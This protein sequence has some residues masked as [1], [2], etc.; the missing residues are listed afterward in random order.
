M[1]LSPRAGKWPGAAFCVLVLVTLGV[2]VVAG[3][4]RA[5]VT[6]I[7]NE[8][9]FAGAL[10][11]TIHES[12]PGVLANDFAAGPYRARLTQDSPA[13]TSLDLNG[14]GSFTFDPNGQ[15][16]GEFDFA[17]CIQPAGGGGCLT[18]ETT[19][20][21]FSGEPYVLS[22]NYNVFQGTTL[23]LAAPGLL[24]GAGNR[25]SDDYLWVVGP[26]DVG[27]FDSHKSGAI[28][29]TP[30]PDFIG[31][32]AFFYCLTTDENKANGDCESYYGMAGSF[33]VYPATLGQSVTVNQDAS[34]HGQLYP[35]PQGGVSFAGLIT[36]A[37][38][39][40]GVDVNNDGTF[41]Y[42]P[43][44][45]Y[46][47]PDQFQF[48]LTQDDV[49]CMSGS[50]PATV[51][52]TVVPLE[53]PTT[54]T[55]DAPATAPFSQPVDVVATVSPSAATGTVAFAEGG[56]PIAGCGA[57]PV[58]GGQ[59]TCTRGGLAIGP[60]VFTASF[61]GSGLYL[62]SAAAP[63]TT[64]VTR[65][66][67]ALTYTGATTAVTGS[68]FTAAARLTRTAGGSTPLPGQPVQFAIT[69]DSCTGTTNPQGIASCVL[70][71]PAPGSTTVS[72]AFAGDGTDQAA[73]GSATVAVAKIPTTTV[74]VPDA[75]TPIWGTA[76]QLTATVS[77]AAS[78][79]VAFTSGSTTISGCD[80]VAVSGGIAV[81]TT[82]DLP[83]GADV[84]TAS[85]S[86]DATHATSSGQ[87]TVTVGLRPTALTYTGDTSATVGEPATL[88]GTLTDVTSGDPVVGQNLTFTR[89]ALTCSALTGPDGRAACTVT[90]TAVAQSGPVTAD[91][92]GDAHHA[93]AT[94]TGALAVAAAPTTTTV[95][96]PATAVF[97]TPVVLT[98]TVTP[99]DGSGTVVFSVGGTPIAGCAGLPLA[100]VGGS[101]QAE[102][103]T[104]ELAV[105]ADEVTATFSG[106]AD[107]TTSSGTATVTVGP[108]PTAVRYTG[109]T[110]GTVTQTLSVSAVLTNIAGSATPIAGQA[111]TF[112]LAD[113]SCTGTTD[114]DGRAACDLTL[115]DVAQTGALT[116]TYAATT[117]YQAATTAADVTVDPVAT[118]TT[119]A[120][121]ATGT[122][123]VPVTI[124]A[125]IA[126]SAGAGT[127]D[128]GS[129]GAPVAG[130][131]DVPLSE[132]SGSWT[133]TC[134]TAA[135][136][137][138]TDT[139]TAEYG[140]DPSYLASS[141]TAVVEIRTAPTALAY[142]GDTTATVGRPFTAA[143]VL[144]VAQEASPAAQ[145]LR[146]LLAAEAP[147]AIPAPGQAMTFSLG[148]LTC[149]ATTDA[150]GTARCTMTPTAVAQAGELV[151][152][153][154]GNEQYVA[155]RATAAVRVARAATTVRLDASELAVTHGE[156]V[157]FTATVSPTDGAGGVTFSSGTATLCRAV[158][159]DSV[160]GQWQASCT[161]TALPIGPDTVHAVYAGDAN[162]LGGRASIDVRV[163][164]EP[165]GGE[166]AP[167][168][169]NAGSVAQTGIDAAGLAGVGALLLL[170]GVGALALARRGRARP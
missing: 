68:T 22:H 3:P 71:A 47:G 155:A 91:F 28:T 38:G 56:T 141:G 169:G 148:D 75:T 142:T 72:A 79:T 77:P 52:I 29:Y 100:D 132:V 107:Y 41:T 114:A 167:A 12:A 96:A 69:G 26:P 105:G 150:T 106:T 17:Y 135:L 80:A 67:T 5:E 23:D 88:A 93:A 110:S 162:Y 2:G 144:T 83:V 94:G 108:A 140:G 20:H 14:D 137:V 170:A 43:S 76:V 112:A 159:L 122:Y 134:T 139:V 11:D 10:H 104:S 15:G 57:V 16:P 35:S 145:R 101:W 34:Y 149:S 161:T 146:P 30:P 143:A 117:D 160:D 31:T 152:S 27:T 19:V 82:S 98:A 49:G 128:F 24:E 151:A 113:L 8:D 164:A 81:C 166:Q 65:A 111:L 4:A 55:L 129:A 92:A 58:S 1:A 9:F 138:G 53:V 37:P 121:P 84:I 116:V 39:H 125:T 109:D 119:V 154:A 62:D 40:G 103:T 48:C 44:P 6:P 157:T 165:D 66:P 158:A 36:A 95:G 51:T 102:C 168:S 54:T 73:T 133:A 13:G 78:G 21:L 163:D 45:G 156:E 86:G 25:T 120:A 64:T 63:V 60:H 59:A 115:T 123:S 18:P 74:V 97:S 136:P 61:T 147:G 124:T 153:F 33:S 42:T 118:T 127:V 126:P 50:S 90:P 130:C 7:A 85:Y 32:V 87:A 46:A 131:T 70:T 89:G 99:T